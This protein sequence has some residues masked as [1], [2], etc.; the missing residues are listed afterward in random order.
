[1]P[2]STAPWPMPDRPDPVA[3]LLKRGEYIIWQ[4]QPV[5]SFTPGFG[6][7]FPVVFGLVFTSIAGFAVFK[8]SEKGGFFILGIIFM[9]FGL[10]VVLHA[11]FSGMLIRR[12]SRYT[13]TNQRAF[14]MVDYPILGPRLDHWPINQDT[15]LHSDH[16]NPMTIRFARAPRL[17]SRSRLKD[18]AFEKIADGEAVFQLMWELR[19]REKYPVNHTPLDDK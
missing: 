10:S 18:I 15:K 12:W 19:D 13:L 2:R 7:I 8:M 16:F 17:F 3:S 14:V 9:G 11:L 6:A 4:G 5:R 1:M